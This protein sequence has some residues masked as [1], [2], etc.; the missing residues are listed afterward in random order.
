MQKVKKLIKGSLVLATIPAIVGGVIVFHPGVAFAQSEL[1]QD[2][3]PTTFA[4]PGTFTTDPMHTSV[5]FDI[6]HMGISRVQ[7]R[8]DDVTGKIEIDPQN[9]DK[10]SVQITIKTNSVDTA[11]A[12]RDED[13]RSKNYFDVEQFPEITF[14][15]TSVKPKGT[16]YVVDGDLTIHGVTKQV[17]I[18]FKKFGPIADMASPGGLRVGFVADPIVIN[19]LDY[20]VGS[21]AKLPTGDYALSPEVNIRI[22][23]EATQP[24]K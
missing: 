8:F 23:V 12:P 4:L 16:G 6:G 1:S 24:K 19:R 5:G 11:V 17:T 7:G 9:I 22:S 14:K 20:K 13:L 10:N 15:S 2:L 18:P 21:D 3:K